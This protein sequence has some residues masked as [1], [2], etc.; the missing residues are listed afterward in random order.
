M[1]KTEEEQE[2]F[3]AARKKIV[4][5][6]NKVRNEYVLDPLE[7]RHIEQAVCIVRRRQLVEKDV[8]IAAGFN[9]TE[10]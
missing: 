5:A 8:L 4:K 3:L 7:A 9:A 10:R 6:A 2:A 1:P